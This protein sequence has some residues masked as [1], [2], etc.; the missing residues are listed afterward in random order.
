[1]GWR[2]DYSLKRWL[3][4]LVIWDHLYTFHTFLHLQ[5]SSQVLQANLTGA[6]VTAKLPSPESALV[7]EAKGVTAVLL[8]PGS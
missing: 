2:S 1:M 5:L 7:T 3:A 4:S 8:E 6:R